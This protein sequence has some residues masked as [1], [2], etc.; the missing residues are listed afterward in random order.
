MHHT[1]SLSTHIISRAVAH[2][3]FATLKFE[4][5]EEKARGTG[6]QKQQAL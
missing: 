5:E 4:M 6:G 1:T 2:A 3:T